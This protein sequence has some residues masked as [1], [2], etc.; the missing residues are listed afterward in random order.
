MEEECSFNEN[1]TAYG[2][3]TPRIVLVSLSN[4]P[5]LLIL[6]IRL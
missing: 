1:K 4:I 6:H 5:D 3:K 2:L